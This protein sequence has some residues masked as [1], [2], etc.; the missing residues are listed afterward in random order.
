MRH[1]T[2]QLR[3]HTTL[4]RP[5]CLW[6][7]QTGKAG[8][9]CLVSGEVRARLAGYANQNGRCWKSKLRILWAAGLCGSKGDTELRIARNII[10]PTGLDRITPAMIA[11]VAADL[12]GPAKQQTGDYIDYAA[13]AREQYGEGGVIEFD[14]SPKV[15]ASNEGAYVRAW[16]FVQK[17]QASNDKHLAGC[18]CD[19]CYCDRMLPELA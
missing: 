18:D 13:L 2:K 12:D 6:C 3:T 11:K 10:G 16:V 1:E 4:A 5:C 8:E 17:P 19:R 15:S 14:D 9:A 7:G